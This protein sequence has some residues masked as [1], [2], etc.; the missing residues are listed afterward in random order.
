MM[1]LNRGLILLFFW[2]ST[3]FLHNKPCEPA[4]LESEIKKNKKSEYGYNM[5]PRSYFLLCPT[6][7]ILADKKISVMGFF[8]SQTAAA[9]VKPKSDLWSFLTYLYK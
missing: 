8:S 2:T 6:A 4:P 3:E 5:G 1:A 9:S 7:E